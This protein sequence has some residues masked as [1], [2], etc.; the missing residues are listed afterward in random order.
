MTQGIKTSKRKDWLRWL[1]G[2]GISVVALFVVFRL[3][4]WDGLS[5]A[6]TTIN[7]KYIGLSGLFTTAFLFVRSQAWRAL[8]NNRPSYKDTFFVVNEGYLL[9][10]LFPLRAGEI[11]RAVIMGRMTGWGPFHILSTIVIERVFD[12]LL[13]AGMLL[14]TLPLV[15]GAVSWGK[16]VAIATLLVMGSALVILFL[17][18][19]NRAVV[20]RLVV[21]FGSHWKFV[22]KY[23]APQVEKLLDGLS[24]LANPRQ[25]LLAFGLICVCWM[26]AIFQYY[27]VILPIV[28]HAPVWYGAFTVTVVALGAAIPSAP[29]ALG[30]FEASIVGA[31]AVLGIDHATALAVGISLHFLQFAITAIFGF[32]GL[33]TQRRSLG[34]LFSE[35][36][37]QQ[38]AN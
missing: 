31:M 23:I 14:G 34:S 26:I 16:P 25:F 37:M 1:P 33:V 35:T 27:M 32:I 13:A 9:N 5:T 10:N 8:L 15:L 38:Q 2:V 7:W 11:G 18:A 30:V 20:D 17:M 12:L 3:A 6:F 28:P 19:R 4:R 29:A 36:R 22:E 21:K 24:A